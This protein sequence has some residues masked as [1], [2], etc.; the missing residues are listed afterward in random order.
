MS[1]L[2][3]IIFVAVTKIR[4]RHVATTDYKSLNFFIFSNFGSFE[5]LFIVCDLRIVSLEFF[6]LNKNIDDS[7]TPLITHSITNSQRFAFA[8][9][10]VKQ[11]LIL[12]EGLHGQRPNQLRL[13]V[14]TAV[15]CRV[16]PLHFGLP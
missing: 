8:N 10:R 6:S 7:M 1:F 2:K 5:N 11:F 3:R 13:F 14:Q 16:F 9:S 15:I 12:L 4:F